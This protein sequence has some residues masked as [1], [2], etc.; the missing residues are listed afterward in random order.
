[1]ELVFAFA[2]IL[3]A[4]LLITVAVTGSTFGTA[5]RGKANTSNLKTLPG[6]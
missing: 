6:A 3:G 5:I 4:I 1:M 2:L